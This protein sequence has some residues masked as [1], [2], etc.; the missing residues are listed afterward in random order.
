MEREFLFPDIGSG[1]VEAEIIKW[2]IA[3]GDEVTSDQSMVEVETEKSVMEIPVPFSGSVV[4]L[5]VAEGETIEVG[6]VLVVIEV[7]GTAEARDDP[8]SRLSAATPAAPVAA[9]SVPPA[10]KGGRPCR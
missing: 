4:R 3:V 7:A 2:H 5:G 8:P 1:L 6:E 10:A 9:A